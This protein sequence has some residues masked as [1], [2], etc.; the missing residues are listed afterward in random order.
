MDPT[1]QYY[2]RNVLNYE[3]RQVRTETQTWYSGQ[4]LG[5]L[6]RPNA[7]IAPVP[8][9]NDA[10]R[11]PAELLNSNFPTKAFDSSPLVL[12]FLV[13]SMALLILSIDRPFSRYGRT[14]PS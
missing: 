7:G 13:L 14:I 11:R 1:L 10:P 6:V 2:S 5:V 8:E 3:D 9:Y 4:D 12:H